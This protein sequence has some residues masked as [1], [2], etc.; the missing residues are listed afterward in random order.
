MATTMLGS[1]KSTCILSYIFT[2]AVFSSALK[3]VEPGLNSVSGNGLPYYTIGQNVTI[4]WTTEFEQTDLV[5]FQ[6][7]P[8]GRTFSY[9][10]LARTV[11][12]AKPWRELY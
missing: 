9:D 11:I 7:R 2:F 3:F 5:V 12:P 1:L 6:R 8:D 4:S 10:L